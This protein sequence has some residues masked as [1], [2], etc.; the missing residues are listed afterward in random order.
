MINVGIRAFTAINSAI[1]N[2]RF[3]AVFFVAPTAAV[4]AVALHVVRGGSA[5]LP[6]VVAGAVCSV[7]TFGITAAG[8]VP[9]NNALERAA[10]HTDA[11]Q[12]SAR[13]RFE[14]PWNRRNLARTVTSTAALAFIAL[15]AIIG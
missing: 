11:Q 8:N 6:A 9:L 7:L 12:R 14:L 5:A 1:L 15:A 3:L 4:A 13:H 2:G 10:I